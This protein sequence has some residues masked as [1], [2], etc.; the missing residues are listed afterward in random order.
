MIKPD[1][2]RIAT[3]ETKM[4]DLA[5][6]LNEVASDVKEIKDILINRYVTKEE[7]TRL[8]RSS[9][10]WKFLSPTLAAVA[11]STMTFLIIEYFRSH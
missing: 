3:L 9:N 1:G 2:E 11:G 4:N 7:F 8:E 6:K 5:D 10:F